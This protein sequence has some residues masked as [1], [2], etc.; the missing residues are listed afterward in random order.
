MS[1]QAFVEETLE[2]LHHTR[3]LFGSAPQSASF[4]STPGLETAHAAVA[5][6]RGAVAENWHGL[7]SGAHGDLAATRIATLGRAIPA[8]NTISALT[9]SAAEAAGQGRRLMDGIIADTHRGIAAIAPS[10]DTPAGKAQLVQHLQAQLSRA[11]A[12]VNRVS[13]QSAKLGTQIAAAA[14]GYKPEDPRR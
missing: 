13:Q 1:L 3:A 9:N 4:A 7:S 8:D 5:T 6:Q 10:T 11:H 2:Q 14:V 12:L